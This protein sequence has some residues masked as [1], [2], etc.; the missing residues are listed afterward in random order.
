MASALMPLSK[1]NAHFGLYVVLY[2]S[3]SGFEVYAIVFKFQTLMY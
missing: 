1:E 2:Y 3:A